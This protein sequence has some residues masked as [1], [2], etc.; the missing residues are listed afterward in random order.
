MRVHMSMHI[1]VHMYIC[2]CLLKLCTFLYTSIC[3]DICFPVGQHTFSIGGLRSGDD[4]WGLCWHNACTV[5]AWAAVPD[6]QEP[7]KGELD[8]PVH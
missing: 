5:L 2:T 4:H 1:S 3:L 7:S 6:P 8:M